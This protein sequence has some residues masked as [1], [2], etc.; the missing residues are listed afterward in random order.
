MSELLQIVQ[1]FG[2]KNNKPILVLLLV[3][4]CYYFLYIYPTIKVSAFFIWKLPMFL[5]LMCLRSG[6]K[7]V[8][9]FVQDPQ[10]PLKTHKVSCWGQSIQRVWLRN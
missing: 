5:L 9:D 10:T 1:N 3:I 2:E 4:S 8:I 7:G 6:S